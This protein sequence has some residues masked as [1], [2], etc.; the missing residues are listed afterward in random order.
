MVQYADDLMTFISDIRSAQCLFK[1]L[2]QFEKCSGLKVNYT[3]TKAM[4][5]GSSCNNVETRLLSIE[6]VQNY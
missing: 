2:D 5:I 3:K 6:M 1:L 4:W